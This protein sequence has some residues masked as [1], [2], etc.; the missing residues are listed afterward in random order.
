MYLK[1]QQSPDIEEQTALVNFLLTL[2]GGPK[3]ETTGNPD[4]D[5]HIR[6]KHALS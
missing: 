3:L 4:E 1:G 6:T 2:K 5:L